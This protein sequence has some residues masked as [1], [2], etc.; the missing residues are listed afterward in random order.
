MRHMSERL[1]VGEGR[2]CAGSSRSSVE[3]GAWKMR[4]MAAMLRRLV[5]KCWGMPASMSRTTNPHG[6]K[7]PVIPVRVDSASHFSP[8]GQISTTMVA[9]MTGCWQAVS[10]PTWPC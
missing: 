3:I 6:L 7:C 1:L 9:S 8:Y 5:M 10:K 4:A 2:S